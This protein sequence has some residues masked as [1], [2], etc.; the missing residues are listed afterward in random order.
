MRSQVACGDTLYSNSHTFRRKTCLQSLHAFK[1]DNDP[2]L[3]FEE[4]NVFSH[5]MPSKASMSSSTCRRRQCLHPLHAFKRQQ[6]L[7]FHFGDDNVFTLKT[8]ISFFPVLCMTRRP[9]FVRFFF[10]KK[11]RV[12]MKMKI[13]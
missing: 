8:S 10:K 4:D 11:G 9:S 7:H 13:N 5:C 2:H 6:C 3:H 1:G 12:K